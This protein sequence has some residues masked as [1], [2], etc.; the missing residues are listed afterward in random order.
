MWAV[1]V[2]LIELYSGEWDN[3]AISGVLALRF[4]IFFSDD[5]YF[6]SKL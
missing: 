1:L 3:V 4:L 2:G 5:N 6:N